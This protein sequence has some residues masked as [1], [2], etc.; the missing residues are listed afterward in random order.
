MIDGIT[1]I[2]F[3]VKVELPCAYKIS[4]NSVKGVW[5]RHKYS[6]PIVVHEMPTYEAKNKRQS[7]DE[8]IFRNKE[9]EKT[10]EK[11]SGCKG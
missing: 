6:A 1:S 8:L 2:A 4:N 9:L 10:K 11:A 3:A 5:N 7:I